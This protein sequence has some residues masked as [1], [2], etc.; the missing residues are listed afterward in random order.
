MQPGREQLQDWIKRRFLDQRGNQSEA[1]E[2]LGLDQTYLSQL[3]GGRRNPGLNTAVTI[4][5]L[6]GISIESWLPQEDGA[7]AQDAQDSAV[8]AD[9][10]K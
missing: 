5:R 6:T 1:A 8:S 9:D 10:C 3:L 2:F 4:E 7:Q